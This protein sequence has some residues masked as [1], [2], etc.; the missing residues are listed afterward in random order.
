MGNVPTK[1]E[2]EQ[3]Y[4]RFIKVIEILKRGISKRNPGSSAI[5]NLDSIKTSMGEYWRKEQDHEKQVKLLDIQQKQL[6]A[7][8]RRI[9]T[10]HN[11]EKNRIKKLEEMV[12]KGQKTNREL[13]TNIEKVVARS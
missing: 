4:Q 7:Q 10:T 3:Q 13:E 5:T 1:I 8:Y 9:L 2:T 11:I 6:G 12:K